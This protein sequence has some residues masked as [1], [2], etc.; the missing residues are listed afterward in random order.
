MGREISTA[1]HLGARGANAR[2]I[3]A[4]RAG[5]L[6]VQPMLR[7]LTSLRRVKPRLPA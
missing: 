4:R 3:C 7:K 6:E 2:R 1:H 5:L